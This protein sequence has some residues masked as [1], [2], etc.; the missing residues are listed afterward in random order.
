MRLQLIAHAIVVAAVV[1][2]SAAPAQERGSAARARAAV[3][4]DDD[5]TTV[6]TSSVEAQGTVGD[7]LTVRAGYLLDAITTA[8]VDVVAAATTRWTER[9]DEVRGGVDAHAGDATV[10]AGGARSLENDYDS[11][12]ASLGGSVDLASRATTLGASV[13]Y[14]H[15]DVGRADDASFEAEAR[16]WVADLRVVQALSPETLA[17][18]GYSLSYVHGLQSSPYRYVPAGDGTFVLERHPTERLRHAITGRVRHAL[19][20][21]VSIGVDQRVYFDDWGMLATTTNASIAFGLSEA[22]ELELRNRFHYQTAASFWQEGY[23]QQRRYMSADRELSTFLDDFAG[24]AVVWTAEEIGPFDRLRVDARADV[25]YYR[26]FDY[27]YLA[28]R[29]GTLASIG[30]EGAL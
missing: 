15:S 25:F 27:A 7:A 18:L 1:A 6:L 12:T 19:G 16:T 17:A 22:F 14:V 11:W 9:R 21:A 28:G 2:P 20:A 29:I 24:A 23:D 5:D 13:A 10:T 3:Y 30:V 26:Y 8:S 4:H